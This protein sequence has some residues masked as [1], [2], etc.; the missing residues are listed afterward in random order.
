MPIVSSR[1]SFSECNDWPWI[2]KLIPT[3]NEFPCERIDGFVVENVVFVLD[4]DKKVSDAR[5]AI[6]KKA[7]REASLAAMT[8]Y[9][10][11]DSQ[12]KIHP[13]TFVLNS[14]GVPSTG[15]AM[16]T[17]NELKWTDCVILLGDPP[18]KVAADNG[19]LA[20]MK[21]AVA[22]EL[23][24]C[25]QGWVA[26]SKSQATLLNA[27]TWWLEG[28]ADYM[29]AAAVPNGPFH[30]TREEDFETKSRFMPLTQM[31]YENYVFFAWL[32]HEK[33]NHALF[34]FM[35]DIT[36]T[37]GQP[38]MRQS[39]VSVIGADNLLR[40]AEEYTDGLIV[41][42]LGKTIPKPKMKPPQ[43]VEDDNELL[44]M[45][46]EFAVTRGAIDFKN[47]DYDVTAKSGEKPEA[48]WSEDNGPWGPLPKVVKASC[49]HP[50]HYRFAAFQI[51][52]GPMHLAIAA[53]RTGAQTSCQPCMSLPQQQ[54]CLVGTWQ[55]DNDMLRQ[56]YNAHTSALLRTDTTTIDGITTMEF[57]QDGTAIIHQPM[58]TVGS[59]MKQH[60]VLIRVSAHGTETGHWSSKDNM[61]RICPVQS[62]IKIDTTTWFYPPSGEPLVSKVTVS[63]GTNKMELT[64]SCQGKELTFYNPNATLNGEHP[65]WLAHKLK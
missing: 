42:P 15:D 17:Q 44:E 63:G 7:V 24:H 29:A 52:H 64:F 11:I 34:D 39:V 43:A 53:K 56:V 30:K 35:H 6:V 45:A 3:L 32:A 1:A 38:G 37:G 13:V 25:V 50:A 5:A 46:P 40:F 20:D 19:L 59:V 57:R 10:A 23:A 61:M 26:K 16:A 62:D 60:D 8:A 9:R 12:F 48:E 58:Y 18:E 54:Q 49:G 33:G 36:D 51:A 22:H 2:H 14:Q 55:I 27:S 21:F 28:M 31:R 4:R 41:G 65:H 47:G